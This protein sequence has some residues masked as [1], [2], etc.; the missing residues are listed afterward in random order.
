MASIT[1]KE[2]EKG[3]RAWIVTVALYSQS[4]EWRVDNRGI[5]ARFLLNIIINCV[6][7]H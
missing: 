1:C 3:R 2:R 6:R 4:D 7:L 5:N